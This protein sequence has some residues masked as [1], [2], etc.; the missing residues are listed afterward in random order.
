MTMELR[1][2]AVLSYSAG[3]TQTGP[4]GYR[5][6]GAPKDLMSLVGARWPQVARGLVGKTLLSINAYPASV[7]SFS[8]GAT[9]DTYLSPRV[10]SRALALGHATQAPTLVTA[11]PLF[12]ADALL[13]HGDRPLPQTLLFLVGGYP[14]FASLERAILSWLE[15][16]VK[17]AAFVQGFGVA[18]VDAGCMIGR[19]RDARGRVV[20]FPR[21]D[22]VPE[23]DGD[24]LL[25]TLLD[26][27]GQ[28]SI[29]R[30]PTGDRAERS[31][32]GWVIRNDARLSPTLREQ[33]ESWSGS[34]WRRRT[35]YVAPAGAAYQLREGEEP[36]HEL[37]LNFWEFGRRYGFSWLNK[38]RW[39]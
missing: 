14:L 16:R 17:T 32:E 10:F 23:L 24:A 39:C 12:L 34:D 36:S 15:G 1:P 19:D 11:Q 35:G 25:L 13:R 20:Y 31:G 8:A 27:D 30:F 18:E 7:G 3:S 28:V 21:A 29:R 4:E 38:P 6:L 26:A 2:G 5:T 33:L 9:V 22:V 37:E